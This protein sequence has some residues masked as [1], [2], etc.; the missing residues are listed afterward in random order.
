MVS[1]GWGW[2]G[3]GWGNG[4][5]EKGREGKRSQQECCTRRVLACLPACSHVLFESVFPVKLVEIKVVEFKVF[6]SKIS[7]V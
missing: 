4:M 3:M 6:D 2:D 1:S 7:S 5:C